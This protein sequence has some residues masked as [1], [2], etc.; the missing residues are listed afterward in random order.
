L[1]LSACCILLIISHVGDIVVV[2]CDEHALRI[3]SSDHVADGPLTSL[4]FSIKGNHIYAAY[5]N[6]DT[7][8]ILDAVHHLRRVGSVSCPGT[9]VSVTT[10]L[11]PAPDHTTL[12]ITCT[13]NATSTM[14]STASIPHAITKDHRA[15]PT[16]PLL[17]DAKLQRSAY[18]YGGVVRAI[19]PSKA[20]GRYVAFDDENV[21]ELSAVDAR[22]EVVATHPLSSTG[23]SL[24]YV[25]YYSAI[26]CVVTM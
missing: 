6:T 24:V 21:L 2:T 16:Q 14:L 13:I 25:S 5:A 3:V 9:I 12:Y 23:W 4:L 17:N 11:Q 8:L 22:L 15:H 18:A 1:S 7:I 10:L 26:F 20:R 19:L